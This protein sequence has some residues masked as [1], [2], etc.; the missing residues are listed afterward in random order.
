MRP[1]VCPQEETAMSTAT[2]PLLPTIELPYDDGEPMDSP[3]HRAQMELLIQSTHVHW[4]DR[5]DYYTGGNMFVYFSFDQ[6]RTHD[7]RGPDYFTAVGVDGT[8]ERKAWVVWE[9]GGRYPDIIIELLSP[10]TRSDDLGT[11]KSLYE[12]VFRTIEYFCYDPE[13]RDLSGWR[14]LR[15]RYEAIEPGGGGRMGSDVLGASLGLWEGTFD[16]ISG[17]W[18]RLWDHKGRL[19]SLDSERAEA[20]HARAEAEHERAEA[21]HARAETAQQRTA[22]VQE[23]GR[24]LGLFHRQGAQ[25]T[26][27]QLRR[28]G[29][30]RVDRL[31]DEI[32]ALD[33]DAGHALRSAGS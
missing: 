19:V 4:G 7:Y 17:A 1:R 20:E 30:G 23:A 27:A 9:E 5:S 33:P 3:W 6:V 25:A 12:R 2:A 15:G 29:G 13:S 16:R 11:K 14:L 28:V 8:K 10:S 31:I 18:L 32:E 24:F 26:L 22:I 21:E